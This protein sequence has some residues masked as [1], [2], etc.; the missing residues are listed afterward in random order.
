MTSIRKQ[1]GFTAYEL[2]V[3]LMGLAWV[4]AIV[5]VIWVIYHFIAKFW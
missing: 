1:S 2:V 5:G 3:V 4:A